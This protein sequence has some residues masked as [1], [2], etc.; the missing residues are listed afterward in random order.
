MQNEVG[1]TYIDGSYMFGA[2]DQIRV[3]YPELKESKLN[4]DKLTQYIGSKFSQNF[5]SSLRVTYYIKINDG[6]IKTHLTIP[7]HHGS[8]GHWQIKECGVSLK[9]K[10]IPETYLN[11]LPERYRDIFPRAEKGLDMEL[12]CDSLLLAAGGRITCFVF[13]I[14]DR[15]YLPLLKAIHRH[16]ANTYV[17][18][19]DVKRKIQQSIL[20][21]CDRYLT[22]EESLYD[23]FDY[24]S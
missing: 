5:T 23:I 6:R 15:D 10:T 2:I 22:L 20:D 11:K 13:M 17:V 3:D 1:A 8:R 14:N 24:N 4:V 18:G 21:L 19:L 7:Q 16:G 9:G 12:A